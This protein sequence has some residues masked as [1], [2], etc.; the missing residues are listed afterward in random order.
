MFGTLRYG[1]AMLV[2]FGH[3]YAVFQGQLNWTGNYA[4]LS[5]YTL[6]G[7]LMTLV[8]QQTY[9][10][11]V[12]G[13]GRYALNR[14][15]R[16]YPP[17]WAAL[18][19]SVLVVTEFPEA[20]RAIGA[21]LRLP[22]DAAGWTKNIAIFGL[23]PPQPSR[24]VPPAWSLDVEL[25][26]YVLMG[27]LLSRSRAIVA[28]WLLSSLAYL[29][30]A[31]AEGWTFYDTWMLPQGSSVAFALGASVYFLRTRRVPVWLVVLAGACFAGNV[32]FAA[33]LWGNPRAYGVYV[34]VLTSFVLIWGLSGI[35]T[36]ALPSRLVRADRLLGDLAYPIFLCHFQVGALMAH[37]LFND[38]RPPGPALF[39]AALPGIHLIALA[40]H[41]GVEWPVASVRDRVRAPSGGSRG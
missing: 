33:A 27:L 39:L 14:T 1:L 29:G 3:L 22:P 11:S 30:Y 36:P 21:R 12:D 7:Y 4:I 40:L 20:C 23:F 2:A 28:I 15:L 8:L 32:F 25:T 35:S 19:L 17:Y 16:I 31:T 26:F 9:G 13:L 5:F 37:F 6:S 24:L 38:A 10:F 18:L 41:Y 34:S